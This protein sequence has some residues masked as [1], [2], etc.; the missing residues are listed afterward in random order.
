MSSDAGITDHY[1]SGDLLN[2][3][4]AALRADAAAHVQKVFVCGHPQAGGKLFGGL[5]T[6]PVKLIKRGKALDRWPV[7][8][9]A[10]GPQ[11]GL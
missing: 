10:I 9:G 6:P 5:N 11:G 7:R 2:R 4:K 3:L 8:I 1:T